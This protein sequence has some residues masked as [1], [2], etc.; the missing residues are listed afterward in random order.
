MRP[1]TAA[2]VRIGAWGLAAA[3]CVTAATAGAQPAPQAQ[4]P[5]APVEAR[6]PGTGDVWLDTYLADV[7]VYGRQYRAAFVDE[8]VRYHAAPRAMALQL[9]DSGGWQPGDLY[10]ACAVAQQRGRPC[11]HMVE[12]FDAASGWAPVLEAY[13]MPA[14]STNLHRIKR[15]LVETYRRWARPILLDV[16]LQ[17]DFPEQAKDPARR[18]V[19]PAPTPADANYGGR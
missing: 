5:A 1:A 2:P 11:R 9:L 6:V 4:A 18:F 16:P 19:A 10:L 13:D 12:R 14:G 17:A 8:L 7:N 15:A 3:L